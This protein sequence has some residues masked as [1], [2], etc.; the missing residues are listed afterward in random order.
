MCERKKSD[1]MMQKKTHIYRYVF[2]MIAASSTYAI[3]RAVGPISTL[4]EWDQDENHH[5]T[6]LDTCTQF[7]PNPPG[8]FGAGLRQTDR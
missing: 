7:E 8:G 3:T 1:K 5:Q 2:L 4:C 6:Q